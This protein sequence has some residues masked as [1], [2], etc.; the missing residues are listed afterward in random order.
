MEA[1]SNITVT[2]VTGVQMASKCLLPAFDCWGYYL[3]LFCLYNGGPWWTLISKPSL[4]L[5]IV[6]DIPVSLLGIAHLLTLLGTS[7]R[8]GQVW[9]VPVELCG[10]VSFCMFFFSPLLPFF[11][12]FHTGWSLWEKGISTETIPWIYWPVGKSEGHF[13]D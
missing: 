1:Y 13:L 2:A 4:L 9:A 7:Q 10:L 11:G 6:S 5:Y 3:T 12:Q 8:Q